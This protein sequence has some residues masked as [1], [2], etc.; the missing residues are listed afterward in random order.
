MSGIRINAAAEMLGVSP[1]TLRSWERR[2]GYPRPA[3]PPAT[4]A[5]TSSTRSRRCARPC[6][7]PTTS[8]ARSRSPA[9][10]A[11]APRPR[12]AS[13]RRSTASTR[14]APTASS[15]RASR[16]AR[17]SARSRS[18]C[19]PRSSSP[20]AA[21]AAAPSSSTPAAGRPAGS[22]APAGSPPA[23]RA[24]RAC[25]CSTRARRSGS[26]P[27]TPRRSSCSCAA[28]GFRVLLLSAGLAE[29][30]FRSALRALGP[31]RGRDL[32]L[33]GAPRRPRRAAADAALARAPRPALYGYRA[34]RLVAGRDGVP[35][36][37][38]EPGEATPR[39]ARRD[40][41]SSR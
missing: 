25:C 41:D 9:G 31:E 5:S 20:P 36:L 26:R 33:R 14:A 16:C 30:R 8:P 17:S 34:A 7:R 29:G 18:C 40:L 3:A 23:R 32:R 21:P 2:L 12:P 37:G 39:P 1:S 6:A 10:A 38:P 4:T 19:C 22:T 15:R 24:T 13:S 35:S 28:P 11:A 27:C